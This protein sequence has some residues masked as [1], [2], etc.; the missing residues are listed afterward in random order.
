MPAGRYLLGV[1][2]APGTAE[3]VGA[4]T[5]LVITAEITPVTALKLGCSAVSLFLSLAHPSYTLSFTRSPE[6]VS[7]CGLKLYCML[8]Y[9]YI[10]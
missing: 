5:V 10:K 8:L 9:I 1:G 4:T 2:T 3:P 6:C 7:L